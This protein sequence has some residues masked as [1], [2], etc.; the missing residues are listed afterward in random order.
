MSPLHTTP[1]SVM[2]PCLP[3]THHATLN[4]L[5]PLTHLKVNLI[6]PKMLALGL[7]FCQSLP[8]EASVI[9][10]GKIRVYIHVYSDSN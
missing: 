2:F 1:L 3:F 8:V 10:D 9:E 4:S 7:T 6:N 5:P